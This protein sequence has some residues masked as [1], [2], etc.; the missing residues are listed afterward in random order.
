MAVIDSVSR[1]LPGVL[2]DEG[3]YT[4][5]SHFNGLLEYP[6][7]TRPEEF[8]GIKI[9][10]VLISGHHAKIDEWKH[11]EAL[12]NTYY[13]R[14]DMLEKIELSKKDIEFLKSLEK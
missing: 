7:Y 10:Q 8:M 12:K 11:N 9:P 2:A 13:K 4:N 3:S 14:P 6:Q 1:M 5:E